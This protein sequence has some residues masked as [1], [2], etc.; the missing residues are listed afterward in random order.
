VAFGSTFPDEFEG[1]H[2]VD[3]I[4]DLPLLF[5]LSIS[6]GLIPLH[7]LFE[8]FFFCSASVDFDDLLLEGSV[9]PPSFSG[10][11]SLLRSLEKV[12]T[13]PAFGLS[14]FY[15]D[16]PSMCHFF[17]LALLFSYPH[18]VGVSTLAKASRGPRSRFFRQ[19]AP[20]L[21]DV[22]P[23]VLCLTSP[24]EGFLGWFKDSTRRRCFSSRDFFLSVGSN[25]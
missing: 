19:H 21:L 3:F 1:R 24:A 2:P 25:L 11:P 14:S 16:H 18:P 8:S 7:F 20:P 22:S 5:D 23:I 13:G 6:V 12:H 15:P 9:M 17:F 10:F 4:R